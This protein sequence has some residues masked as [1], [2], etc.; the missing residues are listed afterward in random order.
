MEVNR[1]NDSFFAVFVLRQGEC[2]DRAGLVDES[3]VGIGF[4]KLVD[5]TACGDV[6]KEGVIRMSG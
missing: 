6:E 1:R 3:G 4:R 5:S 2:A